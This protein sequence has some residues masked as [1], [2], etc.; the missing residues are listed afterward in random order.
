VKIVTKSILKY[1]RVSDKCEHLIGQEVVLFDIV[2]DTAVAAL[3]LENKFVMI[4]A[5]KENAG[6]YFMFVQ[7][8]NFTSDHTSL[9]HRIL[10]SKTSNFEMIFKRE[11]YLAAWCYFV[12][13]ASR[14][15]VDA[16]LVDV[17]TLDRGFW[18]PKEFVST[19][20]KVGIPRDISHKGPLTLQVVDDIQ[21]GTKLV[22]FELLICCRKMET[23]DQWCRCRVQICAYSCF[24]GQNTH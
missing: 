18:N 4:D 5:I 2:Y 17:W 15:V 9:L 12:L 7:L 11:K 8:L 16:V 14:S 1:P 10:G 19:F 13:Q 24:N 3:W 21:S 23:E 6:T 20:E 22:I